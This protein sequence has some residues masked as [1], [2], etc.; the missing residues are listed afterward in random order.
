M[1]WREMRLCSASTDFSTS[2]DCWISNARATTLTNLSSNVDA[3]VGG[4]GSSAA[5]DGT[6]SYIAKSPER[7]KTY[8]PVKSIAGHFDWDTHMKVWTRV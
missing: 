2:S 7:R 3:R 1:N 5:C 6:A 4:A 8:G